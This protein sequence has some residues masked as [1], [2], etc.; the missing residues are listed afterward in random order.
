VMEAKQ[1][2][3]AAIVFPSGGLPE[4]IEHGVDGLV[5]PN[6]SREALLA[7]LRFYADSPAA[8]IEHGE[9]AR[10]SSERLGT[11]TFAQQWLDVYHRAGE[12]ICGSGSAPSPAKGG[13][14]R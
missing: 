5:C 12:P 3:R 10:R 2:G 8:V 13:D 4:M 9:A 1:A 6:S 14:A 7:A 11:L